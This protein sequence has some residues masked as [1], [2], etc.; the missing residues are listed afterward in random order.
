M[1]LIRRPDIDEY[2]TIHKED[3]ELFHE[4]VN[5]NLF[6]KED[7]ETGVITRYENKLELITDKVQIKKVLDEKYSSRSRTEEYTAGL[8]S[9]TV[10]SSGLFPMNIDYKN[11]ASKFNILK[12]WNNTS[13]EDMNAQKVTNKLSLDSGNIVHKILELTFLDDSRVYTKKRG[14]QN[15]IEL[16]CQDKE[17]INTISNFEDRKQYFVDMA[18]KTLSKFFESELENISPVFNEL[19]IN[20]DGK[21]QGAIDAVVY[22]NKKLTILDWKT[23]KKSASRL[24]LVDKGYTRQLYIYSRMLY[25]AGI[26]TKH[27]LEN[28]LEFTVA[29]FNWNSC[30]SFIHDFSREEV[31]KNKAYINFIYNF[32]HQHMKE[33]FT[34][35][36]EL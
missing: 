36:F 26:I 14:L 28:E 3:I 27:E 6:D 7:K 22:K 16:A 24:Q 23:S 31:N 12:W 10:I 5:N 18:S 8:P 29:F 4:I 32:Y 11:R 33:D 13:L 2:R 15:F 35:E 30:N 19:F 25:L 21:I 20:L 9:A 1:I 34:T 17:I